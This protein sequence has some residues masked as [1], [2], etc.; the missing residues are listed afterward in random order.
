MRMDSL[1]LSEQGND[2][3]MKEGVERLQEL[4]GALRH[5]LILLEEEETSC[6]PVVPKGNGQTG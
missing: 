6:L 3:V 2:L 4:Q 5:A 1:V